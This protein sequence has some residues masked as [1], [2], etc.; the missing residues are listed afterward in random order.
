MAA[1]ILWLLSWHII[2]VN[3]NEFILLERL[4]SYHSTLKTGLNL[5]YPIIDN[6]KS[7]KWTQVIEDN[8]GRSTYESKTIYRIPKNELLFDFPKLNVLTRDHLLVSVNG[9]LF[10][11]I[12]DP[13][14]AL[15]QIDDLLQG[16]QQLAQTYLRDA[17]S[18]LTVDESIRD[19]QKIQH[20]IFKS[21]SG[22]VES[23]GVKVTRFDIQQI[24]PPA[25][26]VDVQTKLAIA[27]TQ[28]E[29][30]LTRARTEEQIKILRT[31]SELKDKVLRHNSTLEIQ[32]REAEA[33][34]Y[35]L[36]KEAQ[37]RANANQMLAEA[38]LNGLKQ[39]MAAGLG[40][41]Y[42]LQKEYTK[43]WTSIASNPQTKFVV[44]PY[45][46]AKFLGANC[47]NLDTLTK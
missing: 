40:T 9:I 26:F 39:I 36:E 15:Y 11:Q 22:L 33:T 10:Y 37:S 20:L 17:I 3:E 38:E 21:F 6:M 2:M 5:T 42:L 24:D 16:L 31:E 14:K 45:E 7:V 4:G 19:K 27:K 8:R 1:G 47:L 41:E 43:A 32:K 46:S 18:Q 29:A 25:S 30:E 34:A 44:I 23:W 35:N 12:I 13:K 28:S